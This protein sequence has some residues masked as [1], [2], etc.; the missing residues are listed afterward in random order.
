MWYGFYGDVLS[1]ESAFVT[2]MD[3]L[4]REIGGRGRMDM[5]VGH[6][7][8]AGLPVVEATGDAH[9]GSSDAK[10]TLRTALQLQLQ[11][12]RLKQLRHRAAA[13]GLDED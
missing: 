6:V 5:K 3:A 10:A 2:R 7:S 8:V 12:L 4:C 13:E 1:S 11:S 9:P